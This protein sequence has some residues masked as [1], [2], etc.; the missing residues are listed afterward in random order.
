MPCVNTNG[1]HCLMNRPQERRI[2]DEER[3]GLKQVVEAIRGA[4][5][6][7]KER[8][9]EKSKGD[10]VDA[11]YNYMTRPAYRNAKL[12]MVWALQK[13]DAKDF[14]PGDWFVGLRCSQPH[15]SQEYFNTTVGLAETQVTGFEWL[16]WQ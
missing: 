12:P 11:V 4:W 9:S 16:S 13:R 7:A 3:D 5:Q 6:R 14:N 2:K 8:Q 15:R 10:K 1:A